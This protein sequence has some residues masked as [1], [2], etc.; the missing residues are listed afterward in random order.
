M[1]ET[2]LTYSSLDLKVLR[3]SVFWALVLIAP[4]SDCTSLCHPPC[5]ERRRCSGDAVGVAQK[6]F[7]RHGHDT[8]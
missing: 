8:M 5:Q 4:C 7:G 6:Y 3:K 1:L 2:S